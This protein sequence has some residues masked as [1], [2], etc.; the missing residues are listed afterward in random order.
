[1]YRCTPNI[2][3]KWFG[4]GD[5]VLAEE[6]LFER[7]AFFGITE[8][9][10]ESLADLCRLLPWLNGKT[11]HNTNMSPKT[12]VDY[13]A[14]AEEYFWEKNAQDRELYDKAIREF[15]KRVADATRKCPDCQY[16]MTVVTNEKSYTQYL[17]L[18]DTADITVRS[19][20]MRETNKLEME[21][22]FGSLSF[23]TKEKMDT[24]YR[25]IRVTDTPIHKLL[26]YLCAVRLRT[27]KSEV[28]NLGG[29]VFLIADELDDKNLVPPLVRL[30]IRMIRE[31]INS[32]PDFGEGML[33]RR[34]M[35]WL[36]LLR[37]SRGWR[38]TA[39]YI[40]ALLRKSLRDLAAALACAR[41]AVEAEPENDCFHNAHCSFLL[42]LGNLTEAETMARG[43]LEKRPSSEWALRQLALT[44]KDKGDVAGAGTVFEKALD[45]NPY[46]REGWHALSTMWQAQGMNE[47][48]LEC[49]RRACKAA[50][51]SFP[52]TAHLC[53]LL[54]EQGCHDEAESIASSSLEFYPRWGYMHF[55][56]SKIHE[57]RE[58]VAGAI[59]E[60]AKAV[61]AAPDEMALR[62]YFAAILI[63]HKRMEFAEKAAKQGMAEFP[64]QAWPLLQLS[65]ICE[66]QGDIAQGLEY[67]RKALDLQ[68]E[69]R[70]VAANLARFLRL[71]RIDGEFKDFC[72]KAIAENPNQGWVWRELC[73]MADTRD[74]RARALEMGAKAL[75]V[76]PEDSEFREYYAMLTQH[77]SDYR[78]TR[79]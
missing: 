56:L 36:A 26:A 49:A 12:E 54:L 62:E 60:A 67:A 76:H 35:D 66:A 47:Q 3:V 77:D 7:Y 15:R 24:F 45:K 16:S 44:L 28:E 2:L 78:T 5:P 75:A 32:W 18:A 59:D 8:L 37:S 68:P 58:D 51:E 19:S 14:L 53:N 6:S 71:A 1:M 46:W 61:E 48:A 23:N 13:S 33:T 25:S 11:I 57:A 73:R 22:A 65:K 27:S 29:E 34:F 40:E 9:F 70:S 20:T 43:E 72:Q 64:G 21:I 69:K 55:I 10:E 38:G 17:E 4:N 30:R 52:S 31:I 50:P 74:D 39:W 79:I 42:A 63:R 41:N